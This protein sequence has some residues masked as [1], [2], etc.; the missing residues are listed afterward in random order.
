MTNMLISIIIRTLNEET[1]LKELFS[2]I[3]TQKCDN[4]RTEVIIG[5]RNN[6][7]VEV[8][9]GLIDG[10]IIVAEGLK[11]VSPKGKIKPIKK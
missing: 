10:D 6:G 3:K 9:S 1:Y 5:S 7:K 4:Y 8:L 11:K 2:S